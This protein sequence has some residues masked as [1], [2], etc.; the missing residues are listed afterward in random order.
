MVRCVDGTIYC[1]VSNDVDARIKTHNAGKGAKY[2]R[3]R[4]PVK[5]VWKE[6]YPDKIAA[7]QREY[8]L[9]NICRTKKLEMI[10]DYNES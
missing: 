7:M 3:A 4:L 8:V 1:G 2:T 6:E 9:K 5:L 10:R